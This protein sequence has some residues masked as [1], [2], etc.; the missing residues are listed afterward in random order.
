MSK[1]YRY[2]RKDEERLT[3]KYYCSRR[4]DDSRI[5]DCSQVTTDGK[6]IVTITDHR[7]SYRITLSKW[8]TVR[9]R[10]KQG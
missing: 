2:P 10:L 8:I 6:S 9:D 7:D 1:W 5:V 4:E 3:G